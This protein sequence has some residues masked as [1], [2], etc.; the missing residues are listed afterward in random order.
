MTRRTAALSELV[1]GY[2]RQI[3]ASHNL[4]DA[5]CGLIERIEEQRSF[6]DSELAE[7]RENYLALRGAMQGY[8]A[9]KARLL[10]LAKA[11]GL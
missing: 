6:T 11:L 5:I 3:S 1:K 2:E 10:A 4:A 8:P 7:L 9:T